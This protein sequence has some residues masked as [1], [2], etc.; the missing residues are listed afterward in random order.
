MKQR[1]DH[2]SLEENIDMDILLPPTLQG[3]FAPIDES[4][5]TTLAGSPRVNRGEAAQWRAHAR[6]RSTNIQ[7]IAGERRGRHESVGG[8]QVLID[9]LRVCGGGQRESQRDDRSSGPYGMGTCER[10]GPTRDVAGWG[11]NDMELLLRRQS[12]FEHRPPRSHR[13]L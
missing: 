8:P 3:G 7:G 2:K 1:T 9:L 12:V 10:R 5:G 4:A 13:D 11:H 6:E